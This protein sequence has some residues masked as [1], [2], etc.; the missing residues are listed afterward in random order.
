MD[1]HSCRTPSRR[2]A[3]DVFPL[4]PSWCPADGLRRFATARTTAAVTAGNDDEPVDHLITRVAA[5]YAS[6]LDTYRALLDDISAEGQPSLAGLTIAV[7][8]LRAWLPD[9]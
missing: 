2:F 1:G 3:C 6:V 4:V 8:Q 5:R 9:D 7:H